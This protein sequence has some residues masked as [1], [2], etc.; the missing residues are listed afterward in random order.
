MRKVIIAFAATVLF[1][2]AQEE[3]APDQQ[4][5]SDVGEIIAQPDRLRERQQELLDRYFAIYKA[6]DVAAMLA[7]FD[8]DIMGVFYPTTLFGRGI[9]AAES[10][11][12]GDFEGRPNAW[13]EMP[14][15]FRIGTDKWATFGES[16]NGD[17]RA[18]LMIIFDLN[19]TSDKIEATYT[20]IAYAPFIQGISV[21]EPTTAME[22]RFDSIFS[23]LA[24]KEFAA[25]AEF[26]ADDAAIFA[27]PP[28]NIEAHQPVITGAA[29]AASVLVFKWGEGAWRQDAFVSQYMQYVFVGIPEREGGLDRVALFT[30]DADPASQNFEKI[31]RIDVMGPSGG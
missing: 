23:A 15:R 11:L 3:A 1:A 13:A 18:P 26:F 30:F 20:Q 5:Q 29:D 27:Y 10:G 2:C 25:A 24:N 9:E 21:D 8:D 4:T 31:S 7:L 17:E 12:R 16:I 6:K 14:H 28:V 19:E 22:A